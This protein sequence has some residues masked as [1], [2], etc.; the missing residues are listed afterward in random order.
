MLI[1]CKECSCVYR[2]N[3]II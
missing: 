3:S 1:I 2:T